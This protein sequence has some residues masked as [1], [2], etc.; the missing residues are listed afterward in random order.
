MVHRECLEAITRRGWPPEEKMPV[1]EEV[2]GKGS[3]AET[4][5]N[6]LT[7]YPKII[8]WKRQFNQLVKRCLTLKYQGCLKEK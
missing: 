6:I 1:I 5:R 4:C 7:Y 3:V 8:K 2:Q